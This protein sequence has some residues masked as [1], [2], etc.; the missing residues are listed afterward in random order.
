MY[1]T[2]I[3]GSAVTIKIMDPQGIIT[4]TRTAEVDNTGNWELLDPI[5]IAFDAPFGKY[6]VTISDGKNQALKYWNVETNKVILINPT[7]QMFDAG[8]LIK[9][10]G[11]VLPNIPIELILENHLGDEL[12]IRYYR[13]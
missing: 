2:A 12:I 4:N 3:P 6:S 11:T 8:E 7:K 9:F 13:S 1:G 10:E 5:N